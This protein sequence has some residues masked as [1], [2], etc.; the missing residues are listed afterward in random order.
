MKNMKI[1]LFHSMCTLTV[2]EPEPKPEISRKKNN[3]MTITKLTEYSTLE[4]KI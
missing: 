3:N 2:L 4:A 1:N